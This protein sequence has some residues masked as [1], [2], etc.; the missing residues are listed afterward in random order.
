LRKS[1]LFSRLIVALH[2]KEE[3]TGHRLEVGDQFSVI[4]PA[5]RGRVRSEEGCESGNA[6]LACSVKT[7]SRGTGAKNCYRRLRSMLAAKANNP[8]FGQS[9]GEHRR[10]WHRAVF[11]PDDDYAG[12][13]HVPSARAVGIGIVAD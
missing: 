9:S 10:H 4:M 13:G 2:L 6:F 7:G 3:I 8:G 12:I 5:T 11:P 1:K